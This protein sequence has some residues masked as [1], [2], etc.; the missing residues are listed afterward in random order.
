MKIP[1]RISDWKTT[2]RILLQASRSHK[3]E[4]IEISRIQPKKVRHA[5]RD[6]SELPYNYALGGSTG[7]Q[8]DPLQ[9][10]PASVQGRRAAKGF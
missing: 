3:L 4:L 10:V 7:R 2:L 1:V 5:Q 6:L 8:D 9:A